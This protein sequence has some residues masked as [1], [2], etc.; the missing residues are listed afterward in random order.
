VA[1]ANEHSSYVIHSDA[2]P[3]RLDRQA[4]M[5]GFED[6]LRHANLARGNKVLDAGC[7][8]GSAAR[9]CASPARIVSALQQRQARPVR[10]A[11]EPVWYLHLG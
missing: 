8:S 11:R 4:R 1:T 7:G 10:V 2:E 9:L 5:Y 6:D 3:L